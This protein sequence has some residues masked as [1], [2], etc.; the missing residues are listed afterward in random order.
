MALSR[1]SMLLHAEHHA[2][3]RLIC[4]TTAYDPAVCTTAPARA[5]WSSGS[6]LNEQPA[7]STSTGL[8]SGAAWCTLGR[9]RPASAAFCRSVRASSHP[10][11]FA[12]ATTS[13]TVAAVACRA[14]AAAGADVLGWSSSSPHRS[15]SGPR[16]RLVSSFV[17]PPGSTSWSSCTAWPAAFAP[18]DLGACRGG[19]TG[20]AAERDLRM[21]SLR[22]G[23]ASL[24]LRLPAD[25]ATATASSGAVSMTKRSASGSA[26]TAGP[27]RS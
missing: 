17:R 23:L 11:A 22:S 6:G 10:A 2:V 8:I 20:L 24:R 15:P 26:S 25:L 18:A 3:R 7:A 21:S 16:R 4:H 14:A 1:S 27:R 5:W 19:R 13:G 9:L 12:A